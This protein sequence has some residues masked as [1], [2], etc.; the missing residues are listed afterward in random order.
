MTRPSW[1]FLYTPITTSKPASH[2]AIIWWKISG[3]SWRSA[4]MPISA[5]PLAW[6]MRVMPERSAPEFRE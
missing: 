1:R 3:G 6:R 5:S 4:A 2:L